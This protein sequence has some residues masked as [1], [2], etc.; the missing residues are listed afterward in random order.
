MAVWGIGATWSGRDVSKEF[1]GY[2][3]AAIGWSR[4]EKEKYYKLMEKIRPGDLIFI[5]AKFTENGWLHVKA[6]GIVIKGDPC[7]DNGFEGQEGI[8]VHWVKNLTGNPAK[9]SSPPEYGSTSTLYE[10]KQDSVIQ[11][12]VNLL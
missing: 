12:V 5:K 8:K 9:I 7:I 4:E 3:T 10:E 1:I 6:I 2:E 11:Q